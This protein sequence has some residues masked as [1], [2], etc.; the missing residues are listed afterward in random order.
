MNGIGHSRGK[1]CSVLFWV[2]C[3]SGPASLAGSVDAPSEIVAYDCGTV[4]LHAL[5][6]IEG[7]AT[8]F[9]ALQARLPAPSPQGYSMALLRDAAGTCGLSLTGVKLV[10]SGRAP[11][12]PALVFTKRGEHGHFLV[13]RPVGHSGKL[14][15]IIDSTGDPIV[16]DAIDLYA[17]PQWTGLALVPTRPDWPLRVAVGVLVISGLT[18]VLLLVANRLRGAAESSAEEVANHDLGLRH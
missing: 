17:S 13:V 12:R 14:I 10:A 16:M 5:L 18:F 7:C 9:D 8:R 4:A 11:D 1:T 2:V 3:C 15:Q 6:A